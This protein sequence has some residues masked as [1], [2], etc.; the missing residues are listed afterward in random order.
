MMGMCSLMYVL[1]WVLSRLGGVDVGIRLMLNGCLVVVCICCILLWISV[2]G[3]CIM[4]R[5]LN[6]L[7]VFMVFVSFVCVILFMFVSMIG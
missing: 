2:I 4:L 3:L 1:S 6:L 7:V 5:K